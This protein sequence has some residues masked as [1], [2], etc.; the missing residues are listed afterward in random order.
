[1]FKPKDPRQLAVDLLPRSAC[2]VQVA[3]CLADSHGI[4]SWGWNSSGPTG[5]GEHAELHC[6]KRANRARLKRSTLYIA[7][8]RRRTFEKIVT[9][10]PCPKCQGIIRGCLEVVYRDADGKWRIWK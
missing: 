4:H 3:A 7:A 8:Q 2:S 1:M 10:R 9:A 5:L 6:L